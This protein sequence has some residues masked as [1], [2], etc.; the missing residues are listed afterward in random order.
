MVSNYLSVF[1]APRMLV[2]AGVVLVLAAGLIWALRRRFARLGARLVLFLFAFS[3]GVVVLATLLREPPTRP[4]LAC[5]GD[6]QLAKLLAGSAGTDVLLNVALFVP[7]AF[8]A[9]LM[10]RAPWRV[11]GA[12]FLVSLA[13]EVVQ[14]LLGVGANDAI[15][16]LANT[17]GASIG[18]GAAAIVLL[19]ADTLRGRRLDTHRT[20]RIALSVAA[21]TAVLLGGPAWVATAKESAATDQLQRYF[22]DTTLADYKA[23]RDATW[24]S[25]L[26][27]VATESDHPS[28]IS[29]RDDTVARERYSW[30]IYFAVRCVI[31]EWTP[32]GSTTIQLNGTACTQP[33]ELRP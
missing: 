14:P 13:I 3:A 11:T 31:A 27:Q 21:G 25:K 6:W 18:A 19:I 15:D 5:L 20:V 2:G 16:L 22:A 17:A 4:C 28:V 10:W 30:S 7:P 33:L 24:D 26:T 32:S 23:H 8:V 1:L 29:R 12:G 9:T